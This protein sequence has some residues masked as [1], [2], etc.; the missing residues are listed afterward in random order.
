M[1]FGTIFTIIFLISCVLAIM[2]VNRNKKKKRDQFKQTL[3]ELADKGNCKISESDLWNNTLI[4]ID[5]AAHQLFFIRA[6]AD[7]KATKEISLLEIQKCRVN[8]S[9]RMVT[10]GGSTHNVMDK[11]ELV[12]SSR[13]PKQPETILEFY[14]TNRDNL[15]LNG[16][17]PLSEKWAGI[18][19]ENI[20]GIAQ[21]K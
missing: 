5:K 20:A 1:D 6:N 21:K 18:V 11:I 9:S 2:L 4:G 7:N 10:N 14:N 16:E 3:F 8:N 17:L 12:L 15:F 13:D 19:N